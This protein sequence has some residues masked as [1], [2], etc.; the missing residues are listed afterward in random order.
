MCDSTT[1][2]G[3]GQHFSDQC[4]LNLR[5]NNGWGRSTNLSLQPEKEMR[6]GNL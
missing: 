6:V 3:G 1:T 2:T 4:V 5:S